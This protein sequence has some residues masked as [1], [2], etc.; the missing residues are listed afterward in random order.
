[1]RTC[2]LCG[3]DHPN[4][5]AACPC[6]Y[7]FSPVDADTPRGISYDRP[8]GGV[9]L[10]IGWLAFGLGAASLLLWLAAG[11]DDPGMAIV[12]YAVAVLGLSFGSLMIAVGYVVRAMW[13]LNGTDKK[14]VLEK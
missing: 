4:G 1:M 10:G 13:F 11:R 3:T 2:P 14:V 9:V 8:T 6:G 7:K 12:T 5:T